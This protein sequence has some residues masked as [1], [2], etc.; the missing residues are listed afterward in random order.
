[1]TKK[2]AS[3]RKS[4][5]KAVAR[6]IVAVAKVAK[7]SAQAVL[8]T[9]RT[10]PPPVEIEPRSPDSPT[11]LALKKEQQRVLDEIARQEL[12]VQDHPTTTTHM[13]DDASDVAEQAT[14]LALRRHLEGQLKEIERAIARAERGTYGMCER[15]GKPI[16][17][18]RLRVIP[19][20]SLCIDCAKLQIHSA[21][22]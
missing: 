9:N 5:R 19:S 7:K 4:V 15:C 6:P 18:E 3:P 21:K 22:R 13:A 14:N 8:L 12:L 20:A 11:L 1:M 16:A 2:D 17:E 10:L